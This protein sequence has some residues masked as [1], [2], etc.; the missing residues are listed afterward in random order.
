MRQYA[1]KAGSEVMITRMCAHL[2]RV[3]FCLH[4]GFFAT[5]RLGVDSMGVGSPF[6]SYA[7]IHL[8]SNTAGNKQVQQLRPKAS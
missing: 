5:P 6:G 2:S 3:H 8:G 4:G 7:K 1:N